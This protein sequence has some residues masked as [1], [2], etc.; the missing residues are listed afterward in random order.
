VS[1]PLDDLV[2]LVAMGQV[3]VAHGEDDLPVGMLI[4]SVREGV[5]YVEVG[6]DAVQPGPNGRAAL[7][8][9]DTGEAPRAVPAHSLTGPY[10]QHELPAQRIGFLGLGR[11]RFRVDARTTLIRSELP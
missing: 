9:L 3:W 6:D 10:R 7:E 1:F 11:R 2:R 5:V 4:A 8:A